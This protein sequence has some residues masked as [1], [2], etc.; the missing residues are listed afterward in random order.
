M[1]FGPFEEREDFDF[2]VFDFEEAFFEFDVEDFDFEEAFFEF[3]VED[4]DFEEVFFEFVVEDFDFEEFV[5]PEERFDVDDDAEAVV[6]EES[7][8]FEGTPVVDFECS[9]DP[10]SGAC[11]MVSSTE[12]WANACSVCKNKHNSVMIQQSSKHL[13]IKKWNIYKTFDKSEK[14]ADSRYDSA[15]AG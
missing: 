13:W 11:V 5:F 8:F 15:N 6:S 4:F 7:F 3:V 2:D 1:A 14:S 12:D 10:F 9:P